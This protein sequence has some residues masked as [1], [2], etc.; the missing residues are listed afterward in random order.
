MPFVYK[1]S[2]DASRPAIQILVIAPY[3]KVRP[4]VVKPQRYISDSMG[5]IK[6]HDA[7][8]LVTRFRDFCHVE[9]LAQSIIHSAQPE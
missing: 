8:F 7:S 3:R 6:T 2:S 4:P 1:T 9:E 5:K